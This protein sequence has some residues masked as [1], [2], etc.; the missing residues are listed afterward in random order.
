M[1]KG[2]LETPEYREAAIMGECVTVNRKPTSSWWTV[3]QTP[4]IWASEAAGY[5]AGTT[6]P[7]AA[8]CLGGEYRLR[9]AHPADLFDTTVSNNEQKRSSRFQAAF[10]EQGQYHSTDSQYYQIGHHLV[11]WVREC[12]FEGIAQRRLV[13]SYWH[14]ADFTGKA[15]Q[16]L[17]LAGS[18]WSLDLTASNPRFLSVPPH[19]APFCAGAQGLRGQE[20]QHIH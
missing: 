8:R 9:I 18:V 5:P 16:A 20:E 15:V 4:A 13:C 2:H 17:Y 6:A 1:A 3:I 7:A 14:W 10:Q 12:K 19:Q 11:Q